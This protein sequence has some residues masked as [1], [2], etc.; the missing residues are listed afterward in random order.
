MGEEENLILDCTPFLLNEMNELL[1]KPIT[2]KESEIIAFQMN[3]GKAPG[4]D[5]FPADFFQ[6]Y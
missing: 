5:G 4:P 3:K 6:E 2:M 1:I